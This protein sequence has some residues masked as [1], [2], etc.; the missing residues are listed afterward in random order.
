ME[1]RHVLEVVADLLRLVGR[2]ID[3]R[4]PVDDVDEPSRHLTTVIRQSDQP[5]G[6]DE[7]LAQA[8]GQAG[9]GREAALGYL[10]SEG[11]VVLAGPSSDLL[12][13]GEVRRSVLGV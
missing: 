3:D 2:L 7:G 5:D 9:R 12:S 10:L 6:D 8:G 1:G 13:S 4:P 11:R